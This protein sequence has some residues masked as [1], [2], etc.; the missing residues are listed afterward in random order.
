MAAARRDSR[1][2]FASGRSRTAMAHVTSI[3]GMERLDRALM[4]LRDLGAEA[5]TAEIGT[6]LADP[7]YPFYL[8]YGTSKMPAYPSARP[9]FDE[10]K[11]TAIATTGDVLGQLVVAATTRGT[12]PRG[13]VSTGLT[14]GSRPVQNRWTELARFQLGTYKRSIH[15]EVR[16][17]LP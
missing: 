4:V 10:M 2:R 11:D 5:M 15:T 3:E 12:S 6:D 8:E 1:G 16:D 7:P 14:E 17:G 13:I 9:A